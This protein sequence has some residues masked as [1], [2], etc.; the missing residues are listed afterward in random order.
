MIIGYIRVSTDDQ[1][2]ARQETLLRGLGAEKLFTD[3]ASGKSTRRDGLQEMLAFVREGDTVI[4]ESYSRLA[5]STRDLLDIVRLLDEKRV[6]FISSKENI[7]TGA[8]AGRL[9]LTIFAGLYQFERECLLERQA[10]GI[11]EAKLSGKYKGRAPIPTDA[12]KFAALYAEW[13]SGAVT[14]AAAHRALG[15]SASTFYRRVRQYEGRGNGD[16]L[17]GTRSPKP[18]DTWKK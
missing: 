15:L 2:T 11:R 10:E 14:A 12:G 8:P 16:T 6:G 4:V 18:P 7:D 5:R 3:R 9:M 17:G 13:K 1:N